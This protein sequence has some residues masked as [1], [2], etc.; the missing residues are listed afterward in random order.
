MVLGNQGYVVNDRP[1]PVTRGPDPQRRSPRKAPSDLR[2]PSDSYDLSV[3]AFSRGTLLR[4][5]EGSVDPEE[6]CQEP[7]SAERLPPSRTS[8]CPNGPT[9]VDICR[10]DP[11]NQVFTR[12][13]FLRL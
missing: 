10:Q 2:A 8:T 6:G 13:R 7:C 11:K 12:L 1:W 4:A 9:P 5:A 3:W